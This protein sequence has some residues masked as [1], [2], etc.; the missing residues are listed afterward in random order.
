M[1]LA[2]RSTAGS[3]QDLAHEVRLHVF[4][5]AA[6]TTHVPQPP[7]IA[8]ALGR[9][10]EDVHAALQQLAANRVV[11]LA[12]NSTN[13]WVAAPFCAVP[14]PFKVEVAERRYWAIC[15]WDAL[16]IPAI[17]GEAG[18]IRA[19]CGDCGAE[20]VLEVRNGSLATQQGVVHFAVPAR[21][22]W[23]NIG[24]T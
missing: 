21:H 14:S 1:A 4:R 17:L 2:D 6:A 24:F 12:P 7:A 22:W 10:L 3:L 8:Q 11:M 19:T 20:L 18:I 15:I 23:D 5:Q 9:P 13:L 16:G